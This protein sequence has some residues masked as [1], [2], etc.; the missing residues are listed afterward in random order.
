MSLATPVVGPAGVPHAAHAWTRR[1][2]GA[3][4]PGIAN[5]FLTPAH[6]R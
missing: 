3:T 4:L 6:T 1:S 2:A 5:T